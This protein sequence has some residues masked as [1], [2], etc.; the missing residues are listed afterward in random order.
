MVCVLKNKTKIFFFLQM[1]TNAL[2]QS[3]D[4]M[5]ML[6]VSIP[7]DHTT[8]S[9]NQD[10]LEMGLTVEVRLFKKLKRP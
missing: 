8:V 1:L 10:I 6:T 3:T 7:M 4:V 9:V 2:Q 5:I